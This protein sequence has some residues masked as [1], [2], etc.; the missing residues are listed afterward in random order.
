MYT[1]PVFFL[2]TVSRLFES[3]KCGLVFQAGGDE[4]G[5]S[6]DQREAE[7]GGVHQ[8]GAHLGPGAPVQYCRTGAQQLYFRVHLVVFIHLSGCFFDF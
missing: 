2:C 7:S 3:S 6:A 4:S 8:L 1:L 5:P